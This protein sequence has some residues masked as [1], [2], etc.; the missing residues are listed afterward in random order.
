MVVDWSK[1]DGK[2]WK[3]EQGKTYLVVLSHWRS[4]QK[5][6]GG[7]ENN[8]KWSLVFDVERVD[9]T[10]FKPFLEWTTTSISLIRELRP[11]IEKAES[12][13]WEFIKII[14]K[15]DLENKYSVLEY[16]GV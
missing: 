11:I 10:D 9:D 7:Q 5:L 1:F 13:R 3:P 8:P 2:Y 16:P 12:K 14:L 6:F 15:R 4:E